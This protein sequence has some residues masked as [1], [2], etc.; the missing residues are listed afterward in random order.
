MYISGK[1]RRPIILFSSEPPQATQPSL[2]RQRSNCE[3]GGPQNYW[4]PLLKNDSLIN[5]LINPDFELSRPMQFLQLLLPFFA[6]LCR[7]FRGCEV[8]VRKRKRVSGEEP[9]ACTEH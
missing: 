6:S 5:S 1:F 9:E 3:I 4:F 8:P 7:N 2:C